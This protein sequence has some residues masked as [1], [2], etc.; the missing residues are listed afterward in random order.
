MRFVGNHLSLLIG[1]CLLV[2]LRPQSSFAQDERAAIESDTIPVSR[3][4]SERDSLFFYFPETFRIRMG[5]SGNANA[6]QAANDLIR[7]W[8]ELGGLNDEQKEFLFDFSYL[9][10]SKNI[11]PALEL[12]TFFKLIWNSLD[13]GLLNQE[14]LQNFLLISERYLKVADRLEWAAFIR[15]FDAFLRKGALW[16]STANSLHLREHT[17]TLEWEEKPLLS[18]IEAENY[19]ARYRERIDGWLREAQKNG[20][21]IIRV[22]KGDLIMLKGSDSLNVR[23]TAGTFYLHHDLWMGQGGLIDWYIAGY[24][25]ENVQSRLGSYVTRVSHPEFFAENTYLSY[26]ELLDREVLGSFEYRALRTAE[27]RFEYPRFNSYSTDIELRIKSETEFHYR[28]GIALRGRQLKSSLSAGQEAVVSVWRG[29]EMRMIATLAEVDFLDSLVTSPNGRLVIYHGSDSIYHNSIQFRYRPY[30]SELTLIR[31]RSNYRKSPYV[32]SHFRVDIFT[33]MVRWNTAEDRVFFQIL[34]SNDVVPAVIESHDYF[35]LGTFVSTGQLYDF[36]PLLVVVNHAREINSGKFYM[37]AIV[38]KTGKTRQVIH[39]MLMNLAADSYI[40]YQPDLG[41]IE[42][43]RKAYH[44][45]LASRNQKDFD[46]IRI[47]SISK[48]GPNVILDIGQNLMDIKGVSRFA[49]NEQKGIFIK[50]RSQSITLAANRDIKFDGTISAGNYEF[51]GEQ[52]KFSYEDFRVDLPKV[53]TINMSVAR[54]KVTENGPAVENTRVHNGLRQTSGSIILDDPKNKSARRASPAFPSFESNEPSRLYFNSPAILGGA[55]DE[56][57]YVEIPPFRIDSADSRDASMMKFE[58]RFIG[59]GIADD[60]DVSVYVKPDNSFGFEKILPSEGW[61]IYGGKGRIFS[62][63]TMSTRGLQSTGYLQLYDGRVDADTLTLFTD[64]LYTRNAQFAFNAYEKGGLSIPPMKG[65]SPEFRWNTYGNILSL[66]TDSLQSFDL[67]NGKV[68]FEGQID[69]TPSGTYAD[70]FL[71][72][73]DGELQANAIRMGA[74]FI[75]AEETNLVINSDLE[76]LPLMRG[77]NLNARF[78]DK[79]NRVV[80][81]PTDGVSEVLDFPFTQMKTEMLEAVWDISQ[82]II[83]IKSPIGLDGT[84]RFVA[85]RPGGDNLVIEAAGAIYDLNQKEILISGISKIPVADAYVI[86]EG[87]RLSVKESTDIS[88]FKN[89]TILLDTINQWHRIVDANVTILSKTR[90]DASGF[91]EYKNDAGKTSRIPFD[92]FEWKTETDARGNRKSYTFGVG[93]VSEKENLELSPKIYYKGDVFMSANL[94]ALAMNG[95]IRFDLKTFP[96]NKAWIAYESKGEMSGIQIDLEK[97]VT[98]FGTPVSAG[99]HIGMGGVYGTFMSDKRDEFDHDLFRPKGQL[100]FDTKTGSYIIRDERASLNMALA[101]TSF[102][103]NDETGE[104]KWEGFH[105]FLEKSTPI[106]LEG[107]GKGQGNLNE[108][109]YELKALLH[110]DFKTPARLLDTLGYTFKNFAEMNGLPPALL[111]RTGIAYNVAHIVGEEPARRWEQG[112]VLQANPL[113]NAGEKLSRGLVI[114]SLD[115]KWSQDKKAFYG[116]GTT[117]ISHMN[118]REVNAEADVYM[119]IKKSGF[120]DIVNL[121]IRFTNN[122]WIFF[123]LEDAD[124]RVY[125]SME[126]INQFIVQNTNLYSAGPSEVVFSPGEMR[127][128]K[129]FLETFVKTYMG[130]AEI[131]ALDPESASLKSEKKKTGF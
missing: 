67:F 92:R 11:Q 5:N 46:R 95:F 6:L 102:S 98:E 37:D 7:H 120:G 32:S 70:G 129:A 79:Q 16:E 114:T 23:G 33:D 131:P 3:F 130:N 18:I 100:S 81:R 55:Y 76:G 8:G 26:P 86:P 4:P 48:G 112:S 118:R 99:L 19:P 57:L 64:S 58:G 74:D 124:L 106:S 89:A 9:A 66:A 17:F 52:I 2:S 50:P 39:N 36:N 91:Y 63:L 126:K 77:K 109:K 84:S 107:A 15:K 68:A 42:V 24:D 85:E 14:E 122:A 13:L 45:V 31:D 38:S 28:G 75:A 1:L 73:F 119:E 123:R 40:E 83:D 125:S 59:G 51:A 56:R 94:P 22:D 108:N 78:E 30:H 96:K 128:A 61:N 34:S 71:K 53:D 90:F 62:D 65:I 21:P 111:D 116:Y 117:G 80:L 60:F 97:T 110:A 20:Y 88:E 10:W 47:E 35:D 105:R 29:P 115:L 121:L 87:G 69:I 72:I 49:I 104:V 41:R 12:A 113:F 54:A 103:L 127:D 82:N 43:L 44:Y 25:P 27:G 93:N 101:Q